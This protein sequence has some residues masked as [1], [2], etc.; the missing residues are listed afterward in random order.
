MAA[1]YAPRSRLTSSSAAWRLSGISVSKV[2]GEDQKVAAFLD[3]SFGHVHEPSFVSFAAA[4]ESLG[5]V[6]GNGYRRAAHLQRQ[7]VSLLLGKSCGEGVD[8]II[9]IDLCRVEFRKIAQAN[10]ADAFV[11]A[12]E[13]AAREPPR[14]AGSPVAGEAFQH[15]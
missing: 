1:A 13:V 12:I 5:D 4:T 8:S 14:V 3:G 11:A 10:A 9:A 7:P 15:A 6:G 2:L